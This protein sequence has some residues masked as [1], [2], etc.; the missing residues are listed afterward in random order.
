MGGPFDVTLQFVVSPKAADLPKDGRV[1]LRLL[2]DDGEVMAIYDHDPDPPTSQWRPGA[3]IRYTK[4]FFVRNVPYVGSATLVV[5]LYSMQTRK[6]VRLTGEDLGGRIYRAASLTLQPS[7]SLVTYGDGWYHSE[8]NAEQGDE[9]RWTTDQASISMRNPQSD[10]VLYLRI[11]GSP[12]ANETPQT[13]TLERDG[14]ALRQLTVKSDTADY[15]LPLAAADL[16]SSP[17]VK[18]LLKVDKTFVPAKLNAD[19]GDGRTLGIR[20]FNAFLEPK[21]IR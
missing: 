13:V 3:T 17:N 18:L 14:R 2:F 20:V 1:L 4:R 16:G 21:R 15:E 19:N 6:N 9:W 8:G 7:S 5:G 10:S 11:G 12:V